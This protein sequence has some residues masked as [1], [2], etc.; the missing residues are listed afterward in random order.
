MDLREHMDTIKRSDRAKKYIQRA[1]YTNAGDRLWQ[2]WE[3]EIVLKYRH[4]L[5]Q[6]AQELDRTL[7]A[8]TGRRH[9]LGCRKYAHH[10]WTGAQIVKLRKIYPCAPMKEVLEAFPFASYSMI[11][12]AA[13][14]FG[15]RRHRKPFMP[16]GNPLLDAVRAR[17]FDLHFSLYDLDQMVSQK[18]FYSKTN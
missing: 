1:G 13:Q 2:P 3:D 10:R 7:I 15:V 12:H 5:K 17:C 11:L 4:D 8:I 6:A 16:T 18:T 14:R 9:T